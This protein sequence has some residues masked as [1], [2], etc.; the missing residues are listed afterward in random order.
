V[1]AGQ[2]QPKLLALLHRKVF[3]VLDLKRRKVT[4]RRNLS[5]NRSNSIPVDM[6]AGR[7]T[8]GFLDC[9]LGLSKRIILNRTMAERVRRLGGARGGGSQRVAL[10]HIAKLLVSNRVAVIVS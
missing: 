9:I 8:S 4:E 7:L 2:L 5:R 3:E 6:S 1:G 10:G